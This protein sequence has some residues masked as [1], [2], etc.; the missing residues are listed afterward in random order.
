LQ[1]LARP[2]IDITAIDHCLQARDFFANK[3]FSLKLKVRGDN[4]DDRSP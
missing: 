2:Q 4:Y 3:K 1:S